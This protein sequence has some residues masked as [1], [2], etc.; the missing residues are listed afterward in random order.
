MKKN[1]FFVILLIG[2]VVAFTKRYSYLPTYIVSNPDSSISLGTQDSVL[3]QTWQPNVKMISEIQVP[4]Y[5]ENDFACDVQLK[6]LS[7]DY[8]KTLV[9]EVV[10][11]YSFITGESGIIDFACE[12][13]KL[14]PGERYRIQIILTDATADGALRI[15]SGSNYGGCYIGGEDIGQAAA[16]TIIFV[17]YSRIFWI[18]AVIFP[19]LSYSMLMMILTKRKWEETVAFSMFLEGIILFCFGLFEHLL[20]GIYV[21][22]IISAITIFISIFLF[23][24]KDINLKDLL[25]PGLF[26]YFALF[27]IIILTCNGEWLGKRDDLRH[28]GLA[29]RDMFYYDS[30]AKHINTTVILPRYLPF[31][32][33]I[34]YLFV[35]M[36]GMF[37]EDILLVAYQTMILNTLIILCKPLQR[38]CRIKK[39]IPV[40]ATIICVPVI[41]FQDVSSTLMVDSLQAAIM[42]YALIC[43]YSDKMSRFNGVRIVCALI[44]LTLIKDVGLILSGMIALIIFGDTLILQIQKKKLNI[45]GL[46]YPVLCAGLVVAAFFSWQ[47]YLTIP[48]KS[49]DEPIYQK[50]VEAEADEKFEIMEEEPSVSAST[51]LS[52]SGISLDKLINVVSGNGAE[53]QY[54][55]ARDFIVELFDGCTFQFASLQFSFID[56]LA[57]CALLITS[58]G[59]FGYWGE[60]K[61]RMHLFAGL[62]CLASMC[63][64]AFLLITYW[65]SFSMYEALKLVSF[66]RYLAPF[67][68]AT[69]MVISYF[70]YSRAQDADGNHKKIQ[71]LIYVWT[72]TL[73]FS[74]P[75]YG[76]VVETTDREEYATKDMVYG[77]EQIAEIF[78]S[79]GRRGDKVQFICSD[80]DGYSEYLFRNAVSPMISDHEYWHIVGSKEIFDEQYQLYTEEYGEDYF[81]DILS[82]E[83]LKERLKNYQY[84]VLFHTDET[85]A[86]SYSDL[87]GGEKAIEDGSIY[88][89]INAEGKIS[90][91]LIGKTGIKKWR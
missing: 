1:M 56:L 2:L 64:C 10:E 40:L 25:S 7:D 27:L 12:R 63:L 77:Y 88:R 66:D 86:R 65:F 15:S 21:I 33:L 69:I 38:D 73:I 55:V 54:Q 44:A 68:C 91:R 28:W 24:K 4:Y 60:E 67:V 41:F 87:F 72:F 5:A 6:I 57:A 22:Y 71:Y 83:E 43:Y 29:V 90:L 50:N 14:T 70:M 9:D 3:E 58:L 31:T 75:V 39:I 34:E 82:E 13:V 11:D 35:F 80:S 48:A 59:Y 79:V 62:M 17:K 47:F 23:N 51:A 26:I 32:T 45:K 30:F 85:F 8:S 19:L 42:A 18:V 20:L 36:N 76:I 52:A 46:I 53:Y 74:M 16:L 81:A 89:V 49:V 37:S 84:L 61:N 78:R